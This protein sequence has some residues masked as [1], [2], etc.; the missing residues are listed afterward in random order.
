MKQKNYIKYLSLF[1]FLLAGLMLTAC[2]PK[3]DV[4]TFGEG[5]W[6]SNVF[7]DQVAKFIIENGYDIEVDVV[8]SDTAIS[9]AGLQSSNIDVSLEIWSDN[10]PSYQADLA[11]NLY[12]EVSV[13]FDDN[14]QG[15]YI[16]KYLQDANPGLVSVMDL[17][18]YTNLFPDPDG[19]G[20]GIIYGGPEGWGATAFLQ[21]KMEAYGLDDLYIFRT[22]DSGA[23]LSATLASAYSQEAPWVGYNWEP[24]WIMGIYDMVLLEDTPY[25]EADFANGIGE[26]AS[27][28]VTVVTRNGFATDYPEINDFLSNY[29]T[30]SAL[31]NLGLGFMQENDGDGEAAAIWFLKNNDSLWKDWVTTAAYDKIIE[32]LNA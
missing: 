1:L 27:V 18:D 3:A 7:H 5:D 2:T 25:S 13:N 10:L 32:A 20:K 12:Q 29:T 16:P 24:T 15:L 6:D 23:T 4:L 14:M 26:F 30:S 21:S 9:I 11:N 8:A 22:I 31:T 28:K 17:K 19:S